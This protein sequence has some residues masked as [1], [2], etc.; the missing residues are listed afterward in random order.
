M[1]FPI[2]DVAVFDPPY[3]N[4]IICLADMPLEPMRG[5]CVVW[6]LHSAAAQRDQFE[7]LLQRSDRLPLFVVLPPADA[8]EPILPL[9]PHLKD[10]HARG[11]L[12]N[13]PL[14]NV[15]P[16]RLLLRHAP[17]DL[18]SLMV[19][20]FTRRGLLNDAKTRSLVMKIF[21]L[22]PT[23]TSIAALSKRLYTSRR[24]LGRFFEARGLPV[25]S[26]WLQFARLM[27]VATKLQANEDVPVFR[28]AT[29]YGYP[30]GFTMSNQMK[31]LVGVR[32]T[33]VRENLGWEWFVEEWLELE[34]RRTNG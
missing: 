31:R 7:W 20:Y 27:F 4:L 2:R 18:P 5:R 15:D 9:I 12:P 26:H 28:I 10:L 21:E 8:I 25:P 17:R 34:R 29:Q 19:S 23:I 6:Y 22:A 1:Y 11:V 16:I 32:P 14:Q 30:D 33:D 24:S 13:G 3:T